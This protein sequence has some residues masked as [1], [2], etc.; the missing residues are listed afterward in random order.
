M[1]TYPPGAICVIHRG[2]TKWELAKWLALQFERGWVPSGTIVENVEGSAP[3]Y[4]RNLVIKQAIARRPELAWVFFVDTDQILYD[5][6][7]PRMLSHDVPLVSAVICHRLWPFRLTAFWSTEPVQ[8]VEIKELPPDGLVKLAACGTGCLLI[9]REV[10]D[11]VPEP[12]FQ[13][14]QINNQ[15]TQEDIYFTMQAAKAGFPP[16][17]DCKLRIGHIAEVSIWPGHDGRPWIEVY[18][19]EKVRIPA[20]TKETSQ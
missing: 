19:D 18:G 8:R 12:W 17:L 14:G 9:K 10:L 11:A 13:A 20:Y 3:A 4:Q 5:D 1:T 2:E 6:T 7:V 16:M 15:L